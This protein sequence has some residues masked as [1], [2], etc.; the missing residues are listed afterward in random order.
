MVTVSS[1]S[2]SL[3]NGVLCAVGKR[4]ISALEPSDALLRVH[5]ASINYHDPIGID[6][7]NARAAVAALRLQTRVGTIAIRVD[8]R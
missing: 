7:H 3:I 2:S 4:G 1:G 5:A 8:R 6:R